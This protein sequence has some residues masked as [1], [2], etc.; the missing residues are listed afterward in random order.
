[1]R[2]FHSMGRT[3]HL[4][5][6]LRAAYALVAQTAMLYR[7]WGWLGMAVAKGDGARLDGWA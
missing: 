2:R 3:I 1:M 5:H 4:P 7:A 6:K